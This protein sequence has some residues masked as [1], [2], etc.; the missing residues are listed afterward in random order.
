MNDVTIPMAECVTERILADPKWPE[1]RSL[2]QGEFS[3]SVKARKSAGSVLLTMK[4][5]VRR[6]LPRLVARVLSRESD[7]SFGET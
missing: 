4:R 2:A 7:L 3:A 1:A 6:D 5:R